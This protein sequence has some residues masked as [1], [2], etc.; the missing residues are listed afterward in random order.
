VAYGTLF[1]FCALDTKYELL[2]TV[3]MTVLAFLIVI[4]FLVLVHELGH[5][6]AAKQ[7]G[8]RVDE[9]GIG[10]PPRIWST[11]RGETEYSINA[12]PF[13]GFVKI[14]G[15][16][17]IE[18]GNDKERAFVHTSRY[19]QA[20]TLAAGVAFNFLFAWLLISGGY[21]AGLPT[22]V[23]VDARAENPELLVTHVVPQSPAEEAG[24]QPGDAIRRVA[25]R[26]EVAALSPQ[27]SSAFI[28]AHPD[29]EIV[30]TV[31]RGGDMVTLSAE[32]DVAEGHQ[33]EIIGI[34]M[35]MIGTLSLPVHEALY[36]GGKATI[37]MSE[38]IA[39]GLAG[40]VRD[41][42]AGEADTE[43]LTGPIGIAGL[44]GDAL[45]IGFVNFIMFM[46]IISIHLAILNLLPIPA[47][48]GGRLL[49][50]AIEAICNR[51]ISPRVAG[52]VNFAGF[53]LLILLMI[54]VTYRDIVNLF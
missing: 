50:L 39:V 51:P 21:M 26:D 31:M 30:F 25:V 4:V 3:F 41:A 28:T 16:N 53:V 54:V 47:L 20:I 12:L 8:M 36:E 48:D 29:D 17:G 11:K 35:D 22:S 24:F 2:Y 14:Y 27:A 40:F 15:E 10:F 23:Q 19:K 18:E 42:I 49:F 38:A 13:G 43:S 45:E 1:S 32:P 7:S 46:A 34:G 37:N 44:A 6:L 33:E 9:F 5:F 52:A